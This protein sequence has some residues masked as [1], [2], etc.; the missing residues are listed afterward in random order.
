MTYGKN[1]FSLDVPYIQTEDYAQALMKWIIN[2]LMIP[3]KSVGLKIFSIPTLQLGDIVNIDYKNS[4]GLD[5][6]TPSSNKFVVY[7]IE[8]SRNSTGPEMTVYVSEV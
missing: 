5:L 6:I 4:S 8:Y 3:K 7:N 2:K 1:E